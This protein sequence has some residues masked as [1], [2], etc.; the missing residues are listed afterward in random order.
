MTRKSILWAILVL[1]ISAVFIF[2]KFNQIPADLTRDEVEFTRL[3]LSLN[4][5]SYTPYSPL[6]TGHTTLYYYLILASFKL[7]GLTSSALRFPAALFGVLCPVI[8]Y[9]VMG[10]SFPKKKLILPLSFLLAILLVSQRWYFSFARFSFEVTFLLFL[11]LISVWF[12]MAYW[13]SKNWKYALG[14]GI[15]AGLAYN[16]YLA[17]RVFF[18]LPLLF[19]LYE[20]YKKRAWRS[21]AAYIIPLIIL[22]APLNLYLS[23]HKDIRIHQQSY[24]SNT[25]LSMGEKLEF[26]GQN[27]V[28]TPLMFFMPGKG[29][30]TGLH[31]YPL[32]PALNP[33]MSLLFISGMIISV[34]R[35]NKYSVLFFIW[36][37]ISMGPTLLTY[38]WEN[39]NMLRTFTALPAV[40]YFS[41]V[42]LWYL[43][44]KIN[45]QNWKRYFPLAVM[46]FL[47]ISIFFELRTYY[48]F[49]TQVFQEAF[50]V[51]D[52]LRGV[53]QKY[54]D[55]LN[56]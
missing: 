11:E 48:V 13:K 50:E 51:K 53:E 27:I 17:G 38:P 19:I 32:K 41:G 39:P 46:L 3:A 8:F 2:Y 49:Q 56:Q 6:A 45:H 14:S 36:L 10:K 7:F 16:S 52:Q 31:N 12:L 40:I 5:Q 9:F 34:V 35:R 26:L 24:F 1:I 47:A 28:A 22:T 29:D 42:T 23:Q 18:I 55:Y 30:V 20:A 33:I 37:V 4:A 21:L 43:Y 44:E 15:F 54:L 25:E